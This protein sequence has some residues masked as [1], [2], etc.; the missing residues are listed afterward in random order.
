MIVQ[1]ALFPFLLSCLTAYYLL[2]QEDRL[3]GEIQLVG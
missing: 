1:F 2:F 3:C